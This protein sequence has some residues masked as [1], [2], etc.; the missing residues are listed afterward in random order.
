MIY[1]L[2]FS[3]FP[4]FLPGV[5]K[6]KK[7]RGS[8]DTCPQ[9]SSP[10]PLNETLLLG[11]T[12]GQLTC[13]RPVLRSALK[14]WDNPVWAASESEPDLPYTRDFEKPLGHLTIVLSDSHGNN[15]HVA[16]DVRHPGDS[17]PITWTVN[18]Q[19]PGELSVNVSLVTVLE[20]EID[21][22]TL[23]NLWQLVAYYYETPAILERGG[24]K[25]NASRV[26]YQYVQAVND[27]SPYFTDL[28]GYLLAEP[29]WLLQ[30]RVTLRLNRQQ[31]TTKKLVMDFTTVI[32]KHIN[33]DRG[34]EDALEMSWALIRR[35]TAGRV[36]T[37]L[38]GS[39]V[40]LECIV[41]TSDP[42]LRVEWML[43]DLSI[44]KDAT[45]KIEIS[46]RGELVIL[47]AT[48]SDSGL[49][50]CMVR[51]KAGVDLI[52]LRLTIKE[53]SLTPTALNGQ[54][55]VVEKG[56][57][58]FIPCEVTSVKPSQTMWYLP[59][60]KI[61]LPTQQTRRTEV[62]E[63]GTLVVRRLTQEDA[64]EYTC[65]ASNLYGVDMIS[66]LVEVTERENSP[67]RAKV[68]TSKKQILPFASEEG[69]GS[70][71]DYQ[72]IIRSFATQI[73]KAGTPQRNHN[74]VSK[75]SRIKDS[76]RKPNKS[77]KELD[78]NRWADIL[79]K[80]NARPSVTL[81]PEQSLP[82]PST[83]TI[84]TSTS[85]P[86]TTTATAISMDANNLPP[87]ATPT[88][89][90]EEPNSFPTNTKSKTEAY[91]TENKMG[92]SERSESLPEVLPQL[93]PP[94]STEPS[95]HRVGGMADTVKA[96]T[97]PLAV[98]NRLTVDQS[99]SKPSI[100]GK[101]EDILVPGQTNRRRPP[102][103]RRKPKMKTFR[104]HGH[105][106]YHSSN[107]H[108]TTV[109]PTTITPTTPTTTT[110]T[111]TTSTTTTPTTTAILVP[112]TM[113]NQDIL[114]AEYV[115]EED[116]GE[117][118]E[119]YDI[120]DSDGDLKSETPHATDIESKTATSPA[121]KKDLGSSPL[122]PKTI[123]RSK[124]DRPPH[125]NERPVE[126]RETDT[127]K[128]TESESMKTIIETDKKG[129]DNENLGE[130]G[131]EVIRAMEREENINI[132]TK[133]RLKGIEKYDKD[134]V[135]E[136]HIQLTT[137]IRPKS[138]TQPSPEENIPIH[139][140]TTST[141]NSARSREKE[142]K[143]REDKDAN[144]PKVKTEIHSFQVVEPVHP[145]L[146]QLKQGVGQT[147][148]SRTNQD[149][150]TAKQGKVNPGGHSQPPRVPPTSRW[151]LHHPYYPL[152][153]GQ[154]SIPHTRH[155]KKVVV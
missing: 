45:D 84:Q 138:N 154:S 126:E 14:Q 117:Y 39:K 25:G 95:P 132:N 135:T 83:E 68:Q 54:K 112:T 127:M 15:A 66:H 125:P 113:K 74:R 27:N 72:E 56:Q 149:R 69:E 85:K 35:G 122:N 1:S 75:T 140:R 90:R 124:L 29:S 103:R 41:V 20:C 76:K 9:C 80:A 109:Q 36:Q 73:P 118:Y 144:K 130:S 50:H 52:P 141:S 31:T 119:E 79:A 2:V 65:L 62:M 49:Y 16:C 23:Q 143:Q 55:I 7:E 96:V 11:L 88:D 155:G 6:C 57:S 137:T 34:S 40:H 136:D 82:E 59:K 152:Y 131:M 153:P 38:E 94:R 128:L 13:E 51:T 120:K 30:P 71:G 19:S 114:S 133:G 93:L 91:S 86:I 116:K 148:A 70:G 105:P 98:G 78:P 129:R 46:E 32:T 48:L 121:R 24:L 61:L 100:E 43:T 111:T 150:N 123:V 151:P 63:N 87:T 115:K 5:I 106:L 92:D 139:A 107:N 33:S 89:T 146:H 42:E 64:G 21:R 10:Q 26:T 110:T 81:P 37:A 77:V 142:L 104:P 108:Q 47:N 101:R 53:L 147:P 102:Y 17:S 4:I 97:D 28:K 3:C 60:N 99:A 22:E 44:V 12:P 8:S 134:Q 18:P 58:F 145:W 67:D